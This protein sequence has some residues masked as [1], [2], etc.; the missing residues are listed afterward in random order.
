[1]LSELEPSRAG[2]GPDCSYS[3]Q[4][5]FRK[6]TKDASQ[7]AAKHGSSASRTGR[8]GA[9][10]CAP[11]SHPEILVVG[12]C[13]L[14]VSPARVTCPCHLPFA[15]EKENLAC[16]ALFKSNCGCCELI[17]L[18]GQVLSSCSPLLGSLNLRGIRKKGPL[19]ADL[20][21]GNAGRDTHRQL[22][23]WSGLCLRVHQLLP[24]LLETF[25]AHPEPK[26]PGRRWG[27]EAEGDTEQGRDQA[28]HG[29]TAAL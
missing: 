23:V 29:S 11:C 17:Q 18:S 15:A 3:A 20:Q 28:G 10:L 7:A 22:P 27:A 2:S 8:G 13:H 12:P 16:F 1:M 26:T 6:N 14:P 21:A 5:I 19:G 9:G 4:R 24:K 25:C